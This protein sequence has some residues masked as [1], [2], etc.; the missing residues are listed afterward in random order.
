MKKLLTERELLT[1]MK[2]SAVLI[3][4]NALAKSVCVSQG[5]LSD[6]LNGKKELSAKVARSFGYR[7]I[8]KYAEGK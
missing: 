8:V 1:L 4:Q 6:I 5:H 7:P 3:G 2:K